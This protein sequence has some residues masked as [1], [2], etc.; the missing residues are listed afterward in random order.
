MATPNPA[1]TE[2]RLQMLSSRVFCE[3]K[4]HFGVGG[5]YA[6]RVT[7]VSVGTFCIVFHTA[8]VLLIAF[9]PI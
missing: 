8:F 9:L 2:V 5:L 1:P 4:F 6:H 7:K 3:K